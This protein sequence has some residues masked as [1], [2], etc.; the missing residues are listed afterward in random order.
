MV[1]GG[2]VRRASQKQRLRP[3]H[4]FFQ[5]FFSSTNIKIVRRVTVLV[6]TLTEYILRYDRGMPVTSFSRAGCVVGYDGVLRALSRMKDFIGRLL[7][8][9]CVN[10]NVRR[11]DGMP[12]KPSKSD[13]EHIRHPPTSRP[14]RPPAAGGPWWRGGGR[15]SL[16]QK[17]LRA[18]FTPPC[19]PGHRPPRAPCPCQTCQT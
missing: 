6:Y 12:T 8:P 13:A 3:A 15:S 2:C 16:L 5:L 14:C 10:I 9:D 4:T 7:R 17:R 11:T 18:E 19:N 1:G